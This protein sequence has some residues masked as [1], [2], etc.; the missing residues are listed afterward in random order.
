MV[1]KAVSFALVGVV[2]SAV[3]FGVFLLVRS[4]LMWPSVAAPFAWA[5]GLCRCGSSETATLVAANVCA[6]LVA[7]SGSYV[8]NSF[9]TFAAESGRQLRISAYGAFLASGIVGMLANTATLVL[10]SSYLPVPNDDLRVS[11]AKGCAI[12]VSFVVNFSLSH[13]VVFRARPAPSDA[14]PGQVRR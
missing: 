13:F 4:L 12:L 6:W 7:A 5:V 9:T 10:L 14:Q 8:M 1:L 2:N 3:D 11:V